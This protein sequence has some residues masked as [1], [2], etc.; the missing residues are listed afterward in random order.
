MKI[1]NLE[2]LST[3]LFSRKIDDLLAINGRDKVTIKNNHGS[4]LSLILLIKFNQGNHSILH[5]FPNKEK[6]LYAF[7]EAEEFFGKESILYFPDSCQNNYEY[8][9]VNNFNNVVLRTEVLTKLFENSEKYF[10]ISYASAL[11]S[12]VVSP[13]ILNKQMN[14][15]SIGEKIDLNFL[16]EL[17]FS[18][19]FYRVDF[20]SSPG[21][22]AV[23][24]GIVDVF[25]FSYKN[26]FRIVFFENK[27]K[28]IK[29]FDIETQLSLESVNTFII[30]SNLDTCQF[31]SKKHCFFDYLNSDFTLV[32][33]NSEEIIRIIDKQF[34]KFQFKYINLDQSVRQ[35]SPQELFISKKEFINGIQRFKILNDDKIELIS[36]K[37][38]IELSLKP[39][40]NFN[41][42]FKLLIENLKENVDNG[43]KNFIS[44]QNKKQQQ[45]LL[46]IFNDLSENSQELF[47]PILVKIQAGFIDEEN[48]IALYTD[49][50]IFER[51]LK[52]DDLASF[53]QSQQ[54][55]I[56][57]LTDLKI[58]DYV[59]H[60]DY[61]IGKFLGL[62]KI[63]V[64]RKFQEC[65]KISF[66]NDDILYV[67]IH[68]LHKISRFHSKNGGIIQLSKLGSPVWKNLK[69]KT[70]RKVK[71]MAFDLIKLYAK[72]KTVKGFA[73]SSD[74]YLQKELEA[75]FEY[76]DTE[77][78]IRATEDFKK[79]M[80]S[81]TPM[82]RL[83]CGDVG[84]GKTEIAI[85]AS[86]KAVCD[87]KQVVILVPT[88]IL[89]F[90]HY[91][92]FSK[93]LKGFPVKIDYLNRFRNIKEKKQ[94]IANLKNGN[95][96][97]LIGTH[98]VITSSIEYKNLGLLIVD[99]EHKFGV[100]MKDKLKTLK[101][102]LDILTLTATPIP[103][104]LQFSLMSARDLSV[105]NTPPPNRQPI[106]TIVQKFSK[107]LIRNAIL[108]EL[109]RNGQVL[110][111]NNCIEDLNQIASMIKHL[112]P[113]A[114]IKIGHG[115]MEGKK[116]EE[117]FLEFIEGKFDVL[118]CTTIV[119]SG[120]DVPNAN[121]MFINDP[122]RF[123]MADL[124]QLRG[125]VGRSNK[126]AFC[127][128]LT[129]PMESITQEAQKRLEAMELLSD[130]GSG[131]QI[132]MKDLEIRGAGDLLG[133]EQ[134]GLISDIG[135]NTY[136]KILSEAI[137]ELKLNHF[138]DLFSEEIKKINFIDDVQIEFD[139][140][141]LIPDGYIN[142]VEERFSI[143]NR[144]AKIQ[145]EKDLRNLEK[146]LIDRFGILPLPVR[147]LLDSVLLKWMCKKIGF[148]KIV[149]KKN[150]LLA[151]FPESSSKYFE[152]STFKKILQ[153]ISI[154]PTDA[155]LKEKINKEG[156]FLV[157][158]KEKIDTLNELQI[159]LNQILSFF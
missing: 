142:K 96:D 13:E 93:R 51:H 104:T 52:C 26:P 1:K 143:Y 10:I 99:E 68:S 72:R 76:E 48:K 21:E 16:N 128:L 98:Q 15:I 87:S 50:Q 130:L 110:F 159:F 86:F 19:Q 156:K 81:E 18:F 42:N 59:T 62:K 85:R 120:L 144:L 5:I 80:E 91:Q 47:E 27:V 49:H 71:E 94:I 113:E 119:E 2:R 137:T 92:S 140:E 66:L 31:S 44:F 89:A 106:N 145:T 133:I 109:K 136:Q 65:I 43:I 155:L 41:K 127:Y 108:Y 138:S 70:K 115:K 61:G 63:E 35:K 111:V 73:F 29:K 100:S 34:K 64:N 32:L 112:I 117:V 45:R 17:L 123:G 38:N 101:S 77:D 148:K 88:T 82:D 60:I 37:N 67:S 33:N 12:K 103:R 36:Y 4:Y 107:D 75:L 46:E 134:S 147:N 14:S 135:F 9:K 141:L 122:H 54:L 116:L 153:F 3:F 57:E 121:T 132:A 79:D 124:H 158:K 69:S 20:V 7:N 114:K 139:F 129:P 126:K 30:L 24:E 53:S 11:S 149:L 157:L 84:F 154:F 78:Q 25:S 22:F 39:Q 151:Y 131:L 97:I 23:R 58:G 125:R 105:I 56:K 8:K 152:S 90:Q 40:P 28:Q 146:E 102:N 118:V 150:T 55:I 83:I 6:A 74:S 95:I